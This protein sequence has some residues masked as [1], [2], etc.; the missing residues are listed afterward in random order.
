MALIFL[1]VTHLQLDSN[2]YYKIEVKWFDD[3][4]PIYFLAV[5]IMQN[6]TAINSNRILLNISKFHNW[7]K[8]FTQSRKKLQRK[9]PYLEIAATLALQKNFR[10]AAPL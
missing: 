2:D 1:N 10:A 8:G 3:E 9:S 7:R 6:I 5:F 4:K